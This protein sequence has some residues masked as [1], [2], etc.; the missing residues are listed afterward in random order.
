MDIFG[1]VDKLVSDVYP[2]VIRAACPISM[3]FPMGL[4]AYY[5]ASAAKTKHKMTTTW[6]FT[7]AYNEPSL[8]I[9]EGKVK[10]DWV[11]TEVINYFQD[12]RML[13]PEDD[14]EGEI[15]ADEFNAHYANWLI[16]QYRGDDKVFW[17]DIYDDI[18]YYDPIENFGELDWYYTNAEVA[19]VTDTPVPWTD[20]YADCWSDAVITTVWGE[21]LDTIPLSFSV[22]TITMTK[23]SKNYLITCLK[24]CL[25]TYL[26]WCICILLWGN[27]CV[28][29]KVLCPHATASPCIVLAL[30]VFI[31]PVVVLVWALRN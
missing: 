28:C 13:N 5:D 12:Y 26:S 17:E 18:F 4:Q 23:K 25:L 31:I 15:P 27:V 2:K 16:S 10:L 24:A 29:D 6:H 9:I 7:G 21:P 3:N 1:R 14:I 22:A 30:S 20:A 8:G 19:P 11:Q